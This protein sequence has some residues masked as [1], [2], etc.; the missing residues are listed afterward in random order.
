MGDTMLC[1][2]PS[3]F[4]LSFLGTRACKDLTL[5]NKTP[6]LLQQPREQQSEVN[7]TFWHAEMP[8][9]CQQHRCSFIFLPHN[10]GELMRMSRPPLE[11]MEWNGLWQ[12]L[13][14]TWSDTRKKLFS[15]ANYIV[16]RWISDLDVSYEPPGVILGS[17]LFLLKTS[18]I[19]TRRTG[20]KDLVVDFFHYA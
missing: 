9:A 1:V 13:E 11:V 14:A 18:V 8:T 19:H 10:P 4:I 17:Y 3:Y 15:P 7:L 2:P 6:P 5:K 20:T 12:L 16:T